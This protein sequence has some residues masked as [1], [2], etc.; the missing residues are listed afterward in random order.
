M[1]GKSL[2]VRAREAI[3]DRA[4]GAN[5]AF[6]TDHLALKRAEAVG[7][8]ANWEELR[9]SARAVRERTLS[10]LPEVLGLLADRVEAAGGRVFFAA[11]A[12]RVTRIIVAQLPEAR[13]TGP[14]PGR[15]GWRAG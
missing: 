6:A 5:L 3:A 14:S 8:I 9:R 4:L 13:H 1:S 2:R 11:E 10:R 7:G 15:S 12:A